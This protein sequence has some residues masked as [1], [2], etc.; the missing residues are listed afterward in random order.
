MESVVGEAVSAVM[1]V[2]EEEGLALIVVGIQELKALGKA[3]EARRA[4]NEYVQAITPLLLK[5]AR[6]FSPTAMGSLR[7]EDL[8]QVGLIRAL[9]LLDVYDHARASV[10]LSRTQGVSASKLLE[11]L[12]YRSA[13]RDMAEHIRRH[14]HDVNV[15]DGASR[16]RTKDE[17]PVALQVRSRDEKFAGS[18]RSRRELDDGPA[19]GG[20]AQWESGAL[21]GSGPATPEELL[22]SAQGRQRLLDAVNQ[23]PS[24]Q[25]EMVKSAFGLG[26]PVQSVRDFARQWGIPRAKLGTLEE[27]CAKLA[28]MLGDE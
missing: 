13:M 25:R 26:R 10:A 21:T 1:A 8:I 16:G 27:V 2:G 9:K 19:F 14:A 7:R 12:V 11:D 18:A 22:S 5:V 17:A 20:A 3:S 23:L 6:R 15:S 28:R 4:T 24:E